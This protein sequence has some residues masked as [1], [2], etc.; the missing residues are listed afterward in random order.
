MDNTVKTL[1]EQAK[2]RLKHGLE[3][4]GDPDAIE[5]GVT[6]RETIYQ[7]GVHRLYH[8]PS[9]SDV[10]RP[11]LLVYSLINRPYI[12]DLRPGRSLI[13]YL[14]QNGFDVYLLDWGSPSPEMGQAHLTDLVCETLRRCVRKVQRRHRQTQIDILGYCMGATFAALYTAYRPQDVA[15]LVLLTPILGRT[16]AGVLQKIAQAQDLNR[17]FLRGQLISGRLLKNFFNT[18]KPAAAVKKERDFWKNQ[19]DPQFLNHFLPVEK[20]SND[21]P[22]VPAQVFFEFLESVLY[23]EDLLASRFNLGA[24]TFDF[25][26]VRCPVLAVAAEKDWIIPAESLAVGARVFSQ[27]DYQPYPIPGGHIGLVV[28]RSA[29]QLWQ[30]LLAFYGMF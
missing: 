2:I 23:R 14:C 8:Y 7:E 19:H 5:V 15:K 28:G 22:D 16:E 1:F 9:Q 29:Q 25:S 20:W 3:Y 24:Y 21:T 17:E 13:E 26:Q 6:P 18:V 10:S 27:A 11:L 30:Q 12:F 4:I